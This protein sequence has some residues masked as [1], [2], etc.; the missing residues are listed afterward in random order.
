MFDT[1]CHPYLLKTHKSEEIISSFKLEWWDYLVS[2]WIDIETSI[3]SIK[4]A[5]KHKQIF[6]TIWISPT[7]SL[8]YKWKLKETIDTLEKLYLENKEIVVWIW[9]CWLDYHWIPSL[10]TESINEQTIKEIQKEFFIAQIKLAKKH[11]LPV[12]I[13]N[14]EAKDDTLKILKQENYKNFIFHCFSEDIDFAKKCIE[15]S[16]NCKISFSWIVTFNSAKAIQETAQKIPLKNIIVETDSPYLTPVPYR[17]KQEN[18]PEFVKYV[19]EKI[20]ELRNEKLEAVEKEI[21]K[22]SLEVFKIKK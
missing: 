5:R 21:M 12:I 7:D 17:W 15:F 16:P 6:A 8:A 2:I 9:E 4:L 1:H 10:V 18:K 19:L 3:K 22:N 14:R 11:N 13:H 20:A